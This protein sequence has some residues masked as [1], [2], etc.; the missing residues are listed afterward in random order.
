MAMQ[1]GAAI[2]NADGGFGGYL[3]A[4]RQ[5]PLLQ[6]EQERALVRDARRLGDAAALR[7]L[8][9]SHLRL[10]V[11]IAR[12]FAGYG[13]PHP[14]LVAAG[15]LGLMRAV[16]GFD[17]VHEVRFSTYAT[18]WIRAEIQEFILRSWSMVRIARTAPQ[19][20]LFFNLRRLKARL[21]IIDNGEL[22]PADA[23]RIADA[24]GVAD[25][26]VTSMNR[27]MAGGDLSLDAPLADTEG[28]TWEDALVDETA[29][30][31][32]DLA[33]REQNLRRHESLQHALAALNARERAILMERRLRDRPL[34]LE[35]LAERYGVSRERI[36]QIEV[37]AF[38][39]IRHCMV[40]ADTA[41]A[42]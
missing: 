34:T 35:I 5:F 29:D 10:V 27:R 19:K 31:E 11:K 40:V 6:A 37:R 3:A 22:V 24:L 4:I 23:Q 18:W 2:S 30:Q 9:G 14:D 21:K 32:A 38:Q 15:N 17:P 36:R 25:K 8:I 1:I 7:A 16:K 33:Q 42:P 39:K 26:D 28:E 41:P 12:G 20:R 13:L